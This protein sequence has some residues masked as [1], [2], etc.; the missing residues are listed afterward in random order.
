[1]FNTALMSVVSP[2]RFSVLSA[3]F[4]DGF[5]RFVFMRLFWN[6]VFICL[7]ERFNWS[8]ISIRRSRVM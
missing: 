1:M 5:S 3:G 4:V 6:Q 7:S 8:D 2:I